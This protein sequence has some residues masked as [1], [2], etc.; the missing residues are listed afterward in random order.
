MK[1]RWNLTRLLGSSSGAFL[2]IRILKESYAWSYGG[3]RYLGSSR[4]DA[5]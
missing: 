4:D 2:P 3:I 1:I 5:L